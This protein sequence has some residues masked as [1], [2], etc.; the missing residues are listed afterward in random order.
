MDHQQHSSEHILVHVVGLH[1][2]FD[3]A[4]MWCYMEML[5]VTYTD[6]ATN[7]EVLRRAGEERSLDL[8]EHQKRAS[9]I[10]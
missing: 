9:E 10:L 2:R 1:H 4:E 3:A 7:E 8:P 5:R 6:R